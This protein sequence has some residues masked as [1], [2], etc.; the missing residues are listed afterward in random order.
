MILIGV[1]L[2]LRHVDQSSPIL[3]YLSPRF[4]AVCRAIPGVAKAGSGKGPIAEIMICVICALQVG[5]SLSSALPE[6][7]RVLMLLSY[8]Y[9]L[10]AGQALGQTRQVLAREQ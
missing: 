2:R 7:T 5:L 8:I 3:G 9:L 6:A 10:H 1:T 4:H